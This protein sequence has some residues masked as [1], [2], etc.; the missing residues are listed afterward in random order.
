MYDLVTEKS[1]SRFLGF[2]PSQDPGRSGEATGSLQLS[3]Q[4]Y[5]E[6]VRG[7]PTLC[8]P[9]SV[10]GPLQPTPSGFKHSLLQFNAHTTPDLSH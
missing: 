10:S 3:N 8:S 6:E 7:R 9:L 2:K 4:K 5:Q 1:Q